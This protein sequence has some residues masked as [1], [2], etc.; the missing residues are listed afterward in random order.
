MLAIDVENIIVAFRDLGLFID[1]VPFIAFVKMMLFV[2]L[3]IF[4]SFA[5]IFVCSIFGKQV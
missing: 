4:L 1:C 5:N 2:K 3:C